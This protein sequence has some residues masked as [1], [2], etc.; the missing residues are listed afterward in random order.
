MI[1][2]NKSQLNTPRPGYKAMIIGFCLFLFIPVIF[3][4]FLIIN[5]EFEEHIIYGEIADFKIISDS[6]VD[7]STHGGDNSVTHLYNIEGLDKIFLKSEIVLNN[8]YLDEKN[9]LN[10]VSNVKGDTVT[11]KSIGEESAKILQWK[12]IELSTPLNF[13]GKFW[14]FILILLTLSFF[15]CKTFI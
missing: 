3:F 6:L 4:S 7:A 14:L 13:W 5:M 10:F 15:L 1:S 11:V 9:E 12:D 8:S 2:Y